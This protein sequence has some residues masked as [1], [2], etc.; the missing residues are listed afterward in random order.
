MWRSAADRGFPGVPKNC[1]IALKMQNC[2]KGVD[3]PRRKAED[4]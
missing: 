1:E 4:K 2:L 3:N